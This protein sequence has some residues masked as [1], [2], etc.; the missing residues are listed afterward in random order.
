MTPQIQLLEN[1]IMQSIPILQ[2]MGIRLRQVEPDH[3]TIS[4]PLAP[5]HNHKNTV[6]G[7]S[8]Y[9]ACT[10]A[11]Y[12]LIYSLQIQDQLT[13]R[14]LVITKGEMQYIKPT[15]R[16]FVVTAK[17]NPEEWRSFV[18]SLR[19]KKPQRILIECD[20]LHEE[21]TTRLCHFKGEFALL[22]A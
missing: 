21:S 12:T 7:G 4:V 20:V 3:A 14:D 22:P 1:K 13:H 16:D 17:I 8:L 9:A 11:C 5:N 2:T 6:F 10:A 15:V 18:S 19:Q